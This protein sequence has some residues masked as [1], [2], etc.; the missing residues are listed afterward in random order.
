MALVTYDDFGG[1]ANSHLNPARWNDFSQ[2]HV[3]HGRSS[4][5]LVPTL[6]SAAG[7]QCAQLLLRG[8]SALT[9]TEIV[10]KQQWGRPG[11][12]VVKEF[13]ARIC[14]PRPRLGILYAFFLWGPDK[15]TRSDEIDFE[16]IG[17]PFYGR[18]AVGIKQRRMWLNTFDDGL[19]SQ[20]GV[21]K[22]SP[23]PSQAH[24]NPTG[25]NEYRIAWRSD[26][27]QWYINGVLVPWWNR[28]TQRFDRPAAYRSTQG[29]YVPDEKMRIHFNVWAPTSN[30]KN[31]IEAYSGSLKPNTLQSSG[32]LID[33][34]RVSHPHG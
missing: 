2:Y 12:G 6:Q 23:I 15:S 32:M 29:D 19:M 5:D 16:L 34:V 25:W 14:I 30:P 3:T 27:V 31:F 17:N 11:P 8:G 4:M 22:A 28:R 20:T 24:Y 18:E 33:W 21:S 10:S 1:G 7:A 13:V 9:G 26:S